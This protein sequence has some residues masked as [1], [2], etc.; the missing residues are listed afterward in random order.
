MSTLNLMNRREALITAALGTTALSAVAGEKT[1]RIVIVAGPTNHPPGT[2]EIAASARLI[3]HGLDHLALESSR[4][5]ARIISDWPADAS[6]FNDVA[7]FVFVGD[8]FP[9]A[10]M[11]DSDRMMADL[12]THMKR[13][14]GIA[15]LHYATGLEAKHVKADGDHPLLHWLGGYFATRCT[16]HASIAK[17]FPNATIKP[18]KVKH[19]I[20][21]GWKPFTIHDEPYINNWFGKDGPAKGVTVLATAD[22]PPEKPKA[23]PVAWA[24]ERGDGGR[25]A[26][27]VMPHFYRN[28]ANDDLRTLLFNAMVWTAKLA[29]PA[30]GVAVTRP[31]LKSFDPASV[32]PMPKKKANP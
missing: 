25:G 16:H 24:I 31:E 3:K 9:A 13:G 20:L 21:N 15:C 18:A 28:W 23:E 10:V 26:G 8:L 14:C 7:S 6:M 22:L 4:M 29:V 30:G 11:K 12:A 32:E 5:D 2:H 27:I 1:T 19:E 17:V